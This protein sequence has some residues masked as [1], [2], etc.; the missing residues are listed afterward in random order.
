MTW[1]LVTITP[2]GSMMKPDPRLCRVLADCSEIWPDFPLGGAMS[3][4]VE[5]LTT[6]GNSLGTISDTSMPASPASAGW[7]VATPPRSAAVTA[8][9][10]QPARA[11]RRALGLRARGTGSETLG[12]GRSLI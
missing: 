8:S 12:Y 11:R 6:A 3:W 10:M 5:I 1:L 7:L 9:A 2:D 4:R